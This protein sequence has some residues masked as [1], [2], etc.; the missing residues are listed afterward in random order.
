M[1]LAAAVLKKMIMSILCY[2]IEIIVKWGKASAASSM[3]HSL[4]HVPLTLCEVSNINRQSIQNFVK[5]NG[6]EY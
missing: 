3:Q 2:C 6:F 5:N 1:S 4:Q